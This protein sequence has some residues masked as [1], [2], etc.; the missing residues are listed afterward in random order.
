MYLNQW[1]Y[2]TKIW[3][4]NLEVVEIRNKIFIY[5]IVEGEFNCG[6]CTHD[7]MW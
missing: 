3:K 5:S 6:Q 2:M 7:K 4:K 1:E